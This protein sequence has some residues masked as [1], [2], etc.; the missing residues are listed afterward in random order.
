[1][2]ESAKR[3]DDSNKLYMALA[4]TWNFQGYKFQIV[5]NFELQA[6]YRK[7]QA[8]MFYSKEIFQKWHTEDKTVIYGK[9]FMSG[10]QNFYGDMEIRKEK[11]YYKKYDLNPHMYHPDSE[12]RPELVKVGITAKNIGSNNLQQLLYDVKYCPQIE[13]L[14]KAGYHDVIFD[15]KKSDIL[16]YW[17]ALKICIRNN[18]KIKDVSMYKDMLSALSY[19]NKDLRNAHFVCPENLTK[20][21]DHWIKLKSDAING[22][23][24]MDKMRVARKANP[25]FIKEKSKF[26]DLQIKSGNIKIEPLRSVEDV[27]IE[28]TELNHCVFRSAYYDKKDQLLLSAKVNGKRTETV[29]FSLSDYKVLQSRGYNN[30]NSKHHDKIVNLV[31][32]NIPIIQKLNK[33]S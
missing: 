3:K 19:L 33:V 17:N 8:K 30:K 11:G 22:K 18:Y 13:T 32:K 23:E 24:I 5:R 27:L 26:F 4:D 20:M 15:M 25:K 10:N 12:F 1:M 9:T 21:H 2:L 16:I 28:G 14:L 7:G 29:S 6:Y 31:I